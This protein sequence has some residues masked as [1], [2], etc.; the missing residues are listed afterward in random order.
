MA[1][2]FDE[3]DLPQYSSSSLYNFFDAGWGLNARSTP[4]QV[5]DKF[6]NSFPDIAA[7]GIGLDLPYAG[8]LTLV[9][10]VA[11]A[12]SFPIA[13]GDYVRVVDGQWLRTFC[14]DTLIPVP[15]NVT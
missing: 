1:R 7:S 8:W 4:L 14:S 6:L 11:A 13:F 9:L 15:P 2:S 10:G 5:A 12:S 3:E